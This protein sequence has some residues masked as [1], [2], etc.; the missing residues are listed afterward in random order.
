MQLAEYLRLAIRGRK[1][2]N[3]AERERFA[4]LDRKDDVI[5]NE[6]ASWEIPAVLT[7]G[8]LVLLLLAFLF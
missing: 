7:V 4:E 1:R 2:L 8:A 3:D 6:L 5:G